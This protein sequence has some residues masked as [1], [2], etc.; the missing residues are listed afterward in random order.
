[1]KTEQEWDLGNYMAKPRPMSDERVANWWGKLGSHGLIIK[2]PIQSKKMQS[3]MEKSM[4]YQEEPTMK[5]KIEHVTH[6]NQCYTQENNKTIH[7]NWQMVKQGLRKRMLTKVKVVPPSLFF[8]Q[9][10]PSQLSSFFLPQT[11]FV[12]SALSSP[13]LLKRSM[14]Y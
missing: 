13:P 7:I 9:P 12:W 2:H 14:F 10:L 3:L 4:E 1:M 5:R 8:S 11:L 6:N